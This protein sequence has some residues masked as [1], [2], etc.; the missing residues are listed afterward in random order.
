MPLSNSR[1]VWLAISLAAFLAGAALGR[2]ALG[3]GA[4]EERCAVPAGPQTAARLETAG[5][6]AREL[7]LERALEYSWL[8][9]LRL[10]AKVDSL[11]SLLEELQGGEL[12]HRALVQNAIANLG[13]RELQSIVASAASL[14]AE[15][16]EQI[17]DMP[18]FAARLAEV[19]MEDIVEPG[20]APSCAERVLF[21]TTPETRDPAAVARSHFTPLDARIYAVFPTANYAQGT[22]MIKWYRSDPAQILL[23]RRYAIRPG[24]AYGYVWLNP[25]DGWNPGEYRVD[26]FAADEAVTRLAQGRYS[27][28]P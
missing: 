16:L 17:E 2:F 26:V 4:R 27:V 14:S 8:D 25:K 9:T 28:A 19:A 18:A 22:V 5:S 24:D 6:D 21:T 23:F 13:E 11:E 10:A 3:P 7:E 20:A 12:D 1:S 15:D